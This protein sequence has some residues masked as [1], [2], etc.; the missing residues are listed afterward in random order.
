M[1]AVGWEEP[2]VNLE[3]TAL[4]LELKLSLSADM[5]T[6]QNPLPNNS[7]LEICGEL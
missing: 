4:Y 1:S 3:Q 6:Y 5:L 2:Q 7:K